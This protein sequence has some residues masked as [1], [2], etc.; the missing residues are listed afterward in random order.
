M[1]NSLNHR[2]VSACSVS[3][4]APPWGT[5]RMIALV[6]TPRKA[7]S[8]PRIAVV[9]SALS[10][11]P[12]NLRKGNQEGKVQLAHGLHHEIRHGR[13]PRRNPLL[14]Q[15]VLALEPGYCSA[16]HRAATNTDDRGSQPE[17]ARG[18]RSSSSPEREPRRPCCPFPRP[19]PGR[20][21][22]SSTPSR[23]GTFGPS[24]LIFFFSIPSIAFSTP[25]PVR[26]RVACLLQFHKVPDKGRRTRTRTCLGQPTAFRGGARGVRHRPP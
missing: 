8:C 22:Q 17:T 21:Q 5:P 20:A 26:L 24:R 2:A 23:T 6:L 25:R 9:R 12:P 4:T 3:W 11:Q 15:V 10:D 14:Q 18:S 16:A 19:R 7:C 13:S 1:D